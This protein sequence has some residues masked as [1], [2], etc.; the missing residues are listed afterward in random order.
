MCIRDRVNTAFEQAG[1]HGWRAAPLVPGAVLSTRAL[2][3]T[4]PAD[5][6]QVVGEWHAADAQIVEKALHLSLIHI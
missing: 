1:P 4:N 3:V 2:P 6:R 5:R